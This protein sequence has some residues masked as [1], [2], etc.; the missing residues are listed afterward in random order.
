LVTA[1]IYVGLSRYQLENLLGAKEK[2]AAG[3]VRLFADSC[4]APVNFDDP[5]A[6]EAAV[7]MLG[8]DKDVEYV[9]VWKI[10]EGNRVG[11]LFGELRRGK[12]ETPNWPVTTLK[13]QRRP[14]RV[15]LTSPIRDPG[16]DVIALTT[17]AFSLAPENAAI[18]DVR[19]RTLGISALVGFGLSVLLMGLGRILIVRP[20]AKL[21]T[22]ARRLEKGSIGEI[23][24]QTRDEI[25]QLATAFRSMG[26]AIQNREERI[27]ARNHDMR[28]VL[29]N[30]GQGFITLDIDGKMLDE[31]SL[32]VDT[33]FGAP[34]PHMPFADFLARVDSKTGRWFE[35]GW[36]AVQED[37]L[38]LELCLDQLPRLIRKD[39]SVFE[40]A[41][42]PV[43]VAEKLDKA[44]VVITDVTERFERERMEKAQRE[45]MS[46]FRHTL[47]DKH[48]LE[49]FFAEARS[50]VAQLRSPDT[51]DIA[52]TKRIVHTLKGTSALYGIESIASYCHELENRMEESGQAP[53]EAEKTQLGTLWQ[54]VEAMAAELTR[55]SD[56]I[57]IDAAEYAAF[58]RDIEAQ[59]EHQRLYEQAKAWQFERASDRLQLLAEQATTI[60]NRLGKTNVDVQ[61]LPTRLRL[62]PRRWEPF[63]AVFS[64]A[65]RNAVDHGVESPSERLLA[66]RPERATITLGIQTENAEV[67]VTI[68]DDGR[69]IPWATIADRAKQLGQPHATSADL[70][71]AIFVQGITSAKS[72]TSVS[73]RGVG[74]AALHET[75]QTLGGRVEVHSTSTTGTT[76]RFVLPAEL[77][78]PDAV[79]D[80]PI[81]SGPKSATLGKPVL[82]AVR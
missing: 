81:S 37:F 56:H 34:D 38:P 25:G 15:V 74:L 30:V 22:A 23:D 59:I 55:G 1:G 9:G 20:L 71:R 77:L 44:I 54:A 40:L 3:M 70:E 18:T 62:P 49:A 61:C 75:V 39:N 72:V 41:Y 58:L 7:A 2:A 36:S 66:G 16:N 8:R 73:G 28:V 24:I 33:W 67:V 68:R 51:G 43:F 17:V 27:N 80:A 12:S 6:V 13:L 46:I 14:E 76:F 53:S 64:H 78:V 65:L 69:G 45:M 63:W 60:A 47:S 82:S 26:L 52:L 48:A 10:A 4:A 11:E 50:L 5:Q 19:K 57:E 31:R 29:D 79:Q 21:I 32:V 42:R 35:L